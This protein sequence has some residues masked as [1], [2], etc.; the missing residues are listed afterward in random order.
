MDQVVEMIIGF[1]VVSVM[2]FLPIPVFSAAIIFICS[3]IR[4]KSRSAGLKSRF[5]LPE[6]FL[7]AIL[8]IPFHAACTLLPYAQNKS[9]SNFVEIIIL[10]AIWSV[11]L[12]IRGILS[13]SD[14]PKY[15]VCARLSNILVFLC[16][17]LM[18][19][20]FPCLVE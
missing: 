18:A 2:F 13:F 3:R 10:S 12:I 5:L 15:V 20:F 8:A 7:V 16:S 9:M 19:Y 1:M 14:F 4:R 6:D 11:F 17:V